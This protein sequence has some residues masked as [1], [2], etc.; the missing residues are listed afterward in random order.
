MYGE[1]VPELTSRCSTSDLK[2][3]AENDGSQQQP[4]NIQESCVVNEQSILFAG[5]I[6]GQLIDCCSREEAC[7]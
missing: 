5:A 2:Q 1:I 7:L 3:E 6:N 4:L